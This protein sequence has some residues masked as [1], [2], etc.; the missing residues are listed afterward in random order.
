MGATKQ[1]TK[2]WVQLVIFGVLVGIA[3]M[4]L[5]KRWSITRDSAIVCRVALVVP[6]SNGIVA[7]LVDN[8]VGERP[9]I[10]QCKVKDRQHVRLTATDNVSGHLQAREKVTCSANGTSFIVGLPALRFATC[11]NVGSCHVALR[12][13]NSEPK[14]LCTL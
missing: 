9:C 2:Y 8:P 7:T 10:C 4:V 1:I 13:W 5:V 6:I 14:Q 11:A 12:Y 3:G